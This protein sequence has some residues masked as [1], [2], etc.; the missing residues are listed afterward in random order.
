MRGGRLRTL[1]RGVLQQTLVGP[2]AAGRLRDEGWPYG[3]RA[4]VAV[5]Y[6]IFALA[7]LTVVVSGPLRRSTTLLIT[8][9]T[10]LGLPASSVGLLVLLLSFGVACFAVAALHGPWW[11]K[12]LG[13]LLA[14][15]LMGAWSIRAPALAGGWTWPL[16]GLVSVLAGLVLAIVRWRAPFRWPE[17]AV[18]WFLVALA[19]LSGV[20]EGRYGRTFGND[21]VPLSLQQT[22]ALLGFLALPAATVAGAAV[23]E[24]TV[25]AT[26]AATRGGQQLTRPAWAYAL[27]AVLLGLRLVQVGWQ[28]AHRDPVSQSWNLLLPAL[29]V[30]G[31]FALVGGVLLRLGRRAGAQPVV[32]E[33][34]DELSGI[35]FPVA[36]ALFAVLVPVQL[37]GAAVPVLISLRPD[38]AAG[39]SWVNNA[40]QLV[41]ALVDPIRALVGA[42]L[43]ALAVRAARRGR[44]GRALVLGCVGVM[45]VA[46]AR[47]LLLGDAA[48]GVTDP[49]TLNLVATGL[50][51]AAV[52]AALVSRRL[53]PSRAVAGAGVLVLSALFAYRTV[54]ADPLGVLLGFPGA[55]LLLVG[56]TWD[57][58][59]GA[60]W[61][62]GSSRRFPR[63]TRVLLVL[64]NAVLTMTVLAYA[65]LV[66]DGSTTVY[67]DPYAELGDLVFGTALLAAAVIAVLDAAWRGRPVG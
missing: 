13:L 1:G 30:T 36:A 46:L 48:A 47:R 58:F 64:T 3:L 51:V 67:L 65:A 49:D 57:L 28:L 24:I 34:G 55:A 41:G 45:L 62:N 33:L 9:N 59:T 7:G 42:A 12:L 27:L 20:F 37:L 2:V 22:A 31:L 44:V 50:V 52:V 25:R 15:S 38:G 63:P 29:A 39:Q 6:A 8:G 60:D 61:G 19:M 4:V 10:S 17:L 54:L 11:L 56:L 5:G 14:L 23:A 43:I 18:G 16:V 40:P 21:L 32:A 66:R 53:T 35:G 26:V